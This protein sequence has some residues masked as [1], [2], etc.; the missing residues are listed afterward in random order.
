[1]IYLVLNGTRQGPFS[2][3]QINAM[4]ASY[5]IRELDLAWWEGCAD[6]VP[7]ATAPGVMLPVAAVPSVQPLPASVYA[8]PAGS[9][10]NTPSVSAQV[11]AG[12]VEALRQTRPWVLFLAILGIIGTGMMLLGGLFILAGGAVAATQAASSAGPA[13]PGAVGA[14]LAGGIMVVAAIMFIVMAGL[15]LFP[16]IKLFKYAGAIARLTQSGA[17]SDLEDALQQQ[18]SFWKFLGIMVIV[19]FVIY[20]IAI[21]AFIIFGAGVAGAFSGVHSPAF[22]SPAP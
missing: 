7:V 21:I 3:G 4:L 22:T 14:G 20:I 15:Y 18:K 12:T 10:L 5:Q 11:S 8:P 1:M 2:I 19:I 17:V 16:I 13:G 6:W 9:L